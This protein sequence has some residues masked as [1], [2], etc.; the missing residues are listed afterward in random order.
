VTAGPVNPPASGPY[1]DSTP[2]GAADER[3][4]M[5]EQR[6]SPEAGVAL[7][8]YGFRGTREAEAGRRK[9]CALA[10]RDLRDGEANLAALREDLG[11]EAARGYAGEADEERLHFLDR[12]VWETE[13]AVRL[14][15]AAVDYLS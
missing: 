4:S 10:R 14:A 12:M 13:R 8:R 2:P 1:G 3:G 11:R 7:R 15:R 5:S 9:L 6:R